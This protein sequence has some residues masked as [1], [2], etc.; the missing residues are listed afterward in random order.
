MLSA[1]HLL[2]DLR[3]VSLPLWAASSFLIIILY[4]TSLGAFLGLS[5]FVHWGQY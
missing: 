1:S 5:F 2:C 3:Q 4:L